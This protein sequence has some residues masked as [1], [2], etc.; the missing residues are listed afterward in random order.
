MLFFRALFLNSSLRYA[1]KFRFLAAVVLN[2][3]WLDLGK[4]VVVAMAA[5]STMISKD[6]TQAL[7]PSYD[8]ANTSAVVWW[9]PSYNFSTYPMQ[10]MS[11]KHFFTSGCAC[12]KDRLSNSFL[13]NEPLRFLAICN[14]NP[15]QF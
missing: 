11:E 8:L 6:L 4:L 7:F 15:R 10:P 5:S 14:L 1:L 3:L 12:K 2:Q 13:N 9:Q